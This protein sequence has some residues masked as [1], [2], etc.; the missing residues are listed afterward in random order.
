MQTVVST[1]PV[2]NELKAIALGKIVNSTYMLDIVRG[3]KNM[4]PATIRD[5][6]AVFGYTDIEFDD[7]W[8]KAAHQADVK[9]SAHAA[10]ILVLLDASTDVSE[11][12][13]MFRIWVHIGCSPTCTEITRILAIDPGIAKINRF[14]D[15]SFWQTHTHAWADVIQQ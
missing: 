13:A 12:E 3:N 6:V 4:A 9:R 10:A 5:K 14:V 2:D 8:E 1:H 15:E 7:A 11:I